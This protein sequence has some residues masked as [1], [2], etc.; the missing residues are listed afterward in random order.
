MRK[1]LVCA[2]TLI[3]FFSIPFSGQAEA[4]TTFHDV[5][6]TFWAADEINA[7]AQLGVVSGYEDHSFK[8]NNPVTREEF[9]SLL[10]K[11]FNLTQTGSAP[12]FTDVPVERWSYTAIESVKDYFPG[13]SL[14]SGATNFDPVGMA[15]RED[16][17]AALVRALGHSEELQTE[18]LLKGFRDAADISP[19]VRAEVAMAVNKGLLNG[20]ENGT[21][22]PKS[23][24]TRAEAAAIL[25][26]AVHGALANDSSNSVS[27]GSTY[28][29]ITDFSL[30]VGW[31]GAVS[32]TTDPNRV[33]EGESSVS[34]TTTTE[35]TTTGARLQ[36]LS[37]DLSQASN[38]MLRL[39]VEDIEKLSKFEVRLSSDPRM[40]SY[41]G[42][43][44]TRW[45]LVEGWNEIVIPMEKFSLVGSSESF[46][47]VMTTLQVS[48]TQ[49]GELPVTVLF[50]ALY[51][52]Y[53][54]NG[55]VIIQ[56]DDGWESVYTKAYPLM[57]EKGIV[58]NMGIISNL[59]GNSNYA[60]VD[61]LK[62][63][64]AGGWDIFNHTASHPRLTTLTDQQIEA[65]ISSAKAFLIGNQMTRA[66]D[67]LAYPYG[68]FNERVMSIASK[69][70]QFARTVMPDFEVGTPINPYRL[71]TIDLVNDIEPAVYQEAIRTAAEHGTTVIFLLHR[72]EDTGTS[73]IIYRTKDFQAFLDYL[74]S[75]RQEVDVLSISE[76][77]KTFLD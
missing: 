28:A 73:S 72:I 15:T 5:K 61:Q 60:S 4:K 35:N 63:M 29:T 19:N 66:A 42:Y 58:G 67:F 36:D 30:A 39:Y 43:A 56:F 65:E 40:S 76:W 6:S 71:K 77:Y 64:Y 16:V 53:E 21:F 59:V 12:K 23:T 7:M 3:L 26:R 44:H 69:Y 70:S 13:Y 1:Y 9:A 20:Y 37:L 22:R 62:E 8:P 34:L 17:A 68:D 31:Y 51:R 54:G 49:R 75:Y 11:A 24:L 10:S 47:N 57:K 46:K 41:L 32:Q 33:L 74:Y 14:E 52:D 25:Y 38:L 27:N 50:D 18:V 2:F 55:K 48:V 45:Q